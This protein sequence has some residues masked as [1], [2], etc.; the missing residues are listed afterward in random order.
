MRVHGAVLGSCAYM[1]LCKLDQA[2]D[3]RDIDDGRG[4]SRDVLAALGKEAE[5]GGRGK[6][7]RESVDVVQGSPI[8]ERLCVE[9]CTAKCFR[10]LVL[11]CLRILEPG[12]HWTGLAGAARCDRIEQM[13]EDIGRRTH[14][15]TSR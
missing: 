12:R 11:W 8:L 9:Q 4:P 15:L 3:T 1:V 13:M 2:A 14:L 5:E 10:A 6:E 7:D